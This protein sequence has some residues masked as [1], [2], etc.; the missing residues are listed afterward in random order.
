MKLLGEKLP[1]RKFKNNQRVRHRLMPGV[2]YEVVKYVRP[3]YLWI[4]VV[5]IAEP[6][7]K[8]IIGG[9]WGSYES[10]LRKA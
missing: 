7:D 8:I 4:K 5:A 2:I 3:T 10:D 9:T 1:R 6:T